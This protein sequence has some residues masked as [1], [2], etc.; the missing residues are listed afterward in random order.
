METIGIEN[1]DGRRH[2]VMP[3]KHIRYAVVEKDLGGNET[4]FV[5][6]LGMDKRIEVTQE[7]FE[8]VRDALIQG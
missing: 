4:F 5:R 6:S 8:K 1:K 3:L 7:M 2:F